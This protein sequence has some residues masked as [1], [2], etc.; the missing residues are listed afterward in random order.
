MFSWY[1]FFTFLH[2]T[3]VII[4]VGGA[5]TLAV[6]NLRL[7]R[8]P[9]LGALRFLSRQSGFLGRAVMGPAALVTLIAGLVLA[10]LLGAGFT[11]WMSWGLAAIFG[12]MALGGTVLRRAHE[13]LAALAAAGAALDAQGGAVVGTNAGAVASGMAG[14][15]WGSAAAIAGATPDLAR[16]GVVRRRLAVLSV[17]NVVLLLSAV[18]AMVF[19]PAL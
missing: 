9:D 8:E 2:V 19:K 4:W 12:S 16:L 11:L 5:A 3:A 6:I 17:L 13:E 1:A 14:A 10:G 7:E 15:T 18:A